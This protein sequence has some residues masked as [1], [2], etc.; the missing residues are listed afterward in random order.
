MD[1][2]WNDGKWGQTGQCEPA[3]NLAGAVSAAF[4]EAEEGGRVEGDRQRAVA[5]VVEEDV[6]DEELAARREG[7]GAAGSPVSGGR[8]YRPHRSGTGLKFLSSDQ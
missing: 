4:G 5:G 8:R 7:P 1:Q 2:G 6:V 3:A